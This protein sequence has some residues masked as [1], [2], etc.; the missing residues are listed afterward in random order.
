MED[1]AEV[2]PSVMTAGLEGDFTAQHGPS[3]IKYSSI[4]TWFGLFIL[5]AT[6]FPV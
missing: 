5:F 4:F 6:F 2:M 1:Y 3:M